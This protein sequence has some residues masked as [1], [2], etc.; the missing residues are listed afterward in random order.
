MAKTNLKKLVTKLA[1]QSFTKDRIDTSKVKKILAVL[2][3]MPKGESVTAL[4]LYL[5]LI[6]Y[7]L[8]KHRLIIE[9]PFPLAKKQID[10]IIKA[11][12]GSGKVFETEVVINEKLLGGVRFKLGDEMFE[13]SLEDRI[14]QVKKVIGGD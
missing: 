12:G 5:K 3:K 13:D 10:T 7:E 11:S 6:K 2:K 1:A 8:D 4:N 14:F 9:S